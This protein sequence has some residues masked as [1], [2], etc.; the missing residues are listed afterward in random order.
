LGAALVGIQMQLLH[1][2][3]SY[4]EAEWAALTLL[5]D[6]SPYA[7]GNFEDLVQC[8]ST[9][10]LSEAEVHASIQE[11]HY[12]HNITPSNSLF[13]DMRS[14]SA[15][16]LTNGMLCYQHRIKGNDA[17]TSL[18]LAKTTSETKGST[19]L[20]SVA[21]YH[22]TRRI[23][24]RIR[25]FADTVSNSS[26]KP[27]SINRGAM[28]ALL[29]N[30]FLVPRELQVIPISS[31]VMSTSDSI[32]KSSTRKVTAQTSSSLDLLELDTGQQAR[33]QT[34]H[35]A[36]LSLSEAG[37]HLKPFPQTGQQQVLID[38]LAGNS[39]FKKKKKAAVLDTNFD[40][41]V[42][43]TESTL[44]SP[45][46]PRISKPIASHSS[47][48]GHSPLKFSSLKSSSLK[49]NRRDTSTKSKPKKMQVNIALNED[50]A[51][52]YQQSQLASCVVEGVV[53][54]QTKG[55][56]CVPFGLWIRDAARHVNSLHENRRFA[57]IQEQRDADTRL[58][59]QIPKLDEYFPVVKYKCSPDLRPVPI[60]SV[61][62]KVDDTPD[63]FV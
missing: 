9:C 40:C 53:Q 23:S 33:Q 62:S 24:E 43:G 15:V 58:D 21:C 49:S 42:V 45:G 22:P 51:C 11:L 34:D 57:T 28:R 32:K 30:F 1:S 46:L 39:R 20:L 56:E 37:T 14:E 63:S 18:L 54:L 38:A 26:L 27:E 2:L 17:L 8:S 60:V 5:I 59:V 50:L 6:G 3:A 29:S 35:I 7:L 19:A 13:N 10:T 47:G 55:S 61:N 41:K 31:I 16:R 48:S 36:I 12:R 52:S 4:G 25:D 44:Q